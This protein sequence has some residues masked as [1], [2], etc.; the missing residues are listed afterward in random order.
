MASEGSGGHGTVHFFRAHSPVWAR[1]SHCNRAARRAEAGQL[2]SHGDRVPLSSLQRS[3]TARRMIEKRPRSVRYHTDG[4]TCPRSL[5]MTFAVDRRGKSGLPRSGDS[6]SF[7]EHLV[8]R[9][10]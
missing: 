8:P 7:G 10:S 4:L 3:H 5:S 2:R 9:A 1:V 6:E